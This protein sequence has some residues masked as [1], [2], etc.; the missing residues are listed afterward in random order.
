MAKPTGY[1]TKMQQFYKIAQ[2]E[3]ISRQSVFYMKQLSVF[4]LIL[5]LLTGCNK[6]DLPKGVLEEKKMISVLADLYVIDGYMSTL[7]YT[8]SIR[9]AGKNYYATVYKTHNINK[10]TFDTSLKYYSKQPVLLDSMY[11]K[12]DSILK[13]KEKVL[14]KKLEKKQ[15]EPTKSK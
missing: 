7:A 1:S 2:C 8:D 3:F 14:L 10:S 13:K 5:I 12:V 4:L 11:S 15:K 6:N 9:M